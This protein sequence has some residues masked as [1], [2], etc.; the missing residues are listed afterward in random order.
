[1]EG[2][3]TLPNS[4]YVASKCPDTKTKDTTKQEKLQANI[5]GDYT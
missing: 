1:M 4:F 2:E 3:G 5:F